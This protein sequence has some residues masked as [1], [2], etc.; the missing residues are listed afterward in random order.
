MRHALEILA[1]L[2]CPSTFPICHILGL[3][4][5]DGSITAAS[6]LVGDMGKGDD[7]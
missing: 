5:P 6:G 2:A 1:N 3:H 4:V 7:E